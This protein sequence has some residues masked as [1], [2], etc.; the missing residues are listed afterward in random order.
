[1]K[2]IAWCF[3]FQRLDCFFPTEDL[4]PMMQYISP[5]WASS[6]QTLYYL[7]T[8]GLVWAV[9][10]YHFCWAPCHWIKPY[11]SHTSWKSQREE[12][13]CWFQ[14][15]RDY[16]IVYGL[17]SFIGDSITEVLI[18]LLQL[19]M[20]HLMLSFFVMADPDYLYFDFQ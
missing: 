8:D 12:H 17:L 2:R 19:S 6:Y 16:L 4:C 7:T 11:Q 15:H 20:M 14:I 9:I 5:S 1:M 10:G 3:L 13:L 18:K